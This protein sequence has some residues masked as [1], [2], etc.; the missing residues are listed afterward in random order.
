MSLQDDRSSLRSER[1]GNRKEAFS[2][3]LDLGGQFLC[4]GQDSVAAPDSRAAANVVLFRQLGN[5]NLLCERQGLPRVT[6]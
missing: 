6:N 1:E 5:R 4:K 2:T 3:D